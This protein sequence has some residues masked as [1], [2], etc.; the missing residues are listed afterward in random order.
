MRGIKHK[1]IEAMEQRSDTVDALPKEKRGQPLLLR[2]EMDKEVQK[3]IE[4]QS[5]YPSLGMLSL[6][7]GEEL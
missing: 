4:E 7:R 6:Q 5:L 3:Y 2:D 1:Y